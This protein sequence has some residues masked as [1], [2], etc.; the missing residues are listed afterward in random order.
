MSTVTAIYEHGVFRPLEKVDLPDRS[1]VRVIITDDTQLTG[2]ADLADIY[3]IMAERY[4][5]GHH[6]TAERHNE[7]Q[8]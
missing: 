3:E 7:H 2:T 4:D 5:S 6:D 8:P 1:R